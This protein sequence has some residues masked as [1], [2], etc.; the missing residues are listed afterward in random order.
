MGAEGEGCEWSHEVR[1]RKSLA[2]LRRLA[3]FELDH[4]I[5]IELIKEA[6]TN[7]AYRE[8]QINWDHLKILPFGRANV[9]VAFKGMCHQTSD[10]EVAMDAL[11]KFLSADFNKN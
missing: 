8:E 11:E 1:P 6:F 4:V 2:E 7:V 3:V 10:R 9:I 5:P